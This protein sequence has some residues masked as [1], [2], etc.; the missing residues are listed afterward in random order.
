MVKGKKSEMKETKYLSLLLRSL[1]NACFSQRNFVL[2]QE[3]LRS[4]TKSWKA[5]ASKCKV[6]WGNTMGLQANAMFVKSEH[7]IIDL[8]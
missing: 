4:L 8:L 1:S 2:H 6:S 3:T 5:F 7:K